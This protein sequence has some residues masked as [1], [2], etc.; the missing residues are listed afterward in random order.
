MGL[1][2]I[3]KFRRIDPKG[4]TTQNNNIYKAHGGIRNKHTHTA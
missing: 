3:T 2:T 1:H 4:V